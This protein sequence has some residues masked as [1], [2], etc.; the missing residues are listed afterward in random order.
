MNRNDPETVISG[1]DEQHALIE[2]AGLNTYL[3]KGTEFLQY[4]FNGDGEVNTAEAVVLGRLIAEDTTPAGDL[5][6]RMQFVEA[7]IDG[8]GLETLPDLRAFLHILSE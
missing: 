5:T 4:D 8:D 3:R 6:A 1:D 7:N 2:N